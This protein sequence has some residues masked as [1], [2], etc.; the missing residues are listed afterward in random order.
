MKNDNKNKNL[1]TRESRFL[2]HPLVQYDPETVNGGVQ[3]LKLVRRTRLGWVDSSGN[4][5]EVSSS[6]EL[7]VLND[8][9]RKGGGGYHTDNC[10]F[11][12]NP[13]GQKKP[14]EKSYEIHR[15]RKKNHRVGKY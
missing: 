6:L 7:W 4:V 12:F 9:T 3:V 14:A 1:S 15:N 13:S 8:S 11:N 10:I 2:T 5:D